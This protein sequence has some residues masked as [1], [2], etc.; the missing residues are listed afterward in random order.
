MHGDCRDRTDRI[1]TRESYEDAY[2]NATTENPEGRLGGLAWLMFTNR[3]L[4]FLGCSLEQDR[5]VGVLRQIVKRLPGITHYA[6]L[7][8]ET[9][10][11]AWE[12][13]ERQLEAIGVRGLWY[14]PERYEEIEQLLQKALED[15]STTSLPTKPENGEAHAISKALSRA[16]NCS[17]RYFRTAICALRRA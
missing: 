8:A 6:I 14:Y 16:I 1:F 4:L 12:R 9:S 15:S 3:P 17:V 7:A 5:T 10:K 11:Q 13:R 2:G